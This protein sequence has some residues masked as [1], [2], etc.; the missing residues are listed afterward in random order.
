MNSV[1]PPDRGAASAAASSSSST[2]VDHVVVNALF[3]LDAASA[4]F[5]ALG[6]A[7]SARGYHSLGSMNHLVMSGSA[8]LEL[9]GV[10][11][12]GLQR[13]DV[14]NSP[15]GLS[16]LVFKTHDAD[17]TYARTIAEGLSMLTPLDFSRPVSTGGATREARF[18]IV[19]AAPESFPAGRI[20]FCEHLT[21]ELVWDGQGLDHANGFRRLVSITVETT[22]MERDRARYA[23]VTS[24]AAVAAVTSA[25]GD[26]RDP[27]LQFP[28]G[29]FTLYLTAGE[30]DRLV[31]LALEFDDLLF[32]E[33]AAAALPGVIWQR[34]SEH[35]AVLQIP[36]MQLRL[37]C[38]AG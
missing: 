14:M 15:L 4:L 25:A 38:R 34:V 2:E 18:R 17:A 21:P 16:G 11:R 12:T 19:R 33:Q 28:L 20:Y 32:L 37:D 27:T 1:A 24:V 9:V 13:A 8:Y 5:S 30:Q 23:S 36:D 31:D 35:H 10:P 7:V 29:D 22:Q 26:G 3:D 6:F